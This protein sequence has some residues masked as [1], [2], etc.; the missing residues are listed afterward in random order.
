MMRRVLYAVAG[1]VL[2]T[3]GLGAAPLHAGADS[4][5]ALCGFNGNGSVAPP[6]TYQ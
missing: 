2:A 1:L 3:A 4:G 6:V 5:A